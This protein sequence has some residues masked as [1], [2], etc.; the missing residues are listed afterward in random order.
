MLREHVLVAEP[1]GTYWYQ[2]TMR[3]TIEA[4]GTVHMAGRGAQ[5]LRLEFEQGLFSLQTHPGS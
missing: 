2:Q 1:V 3:S 5:R 4:D